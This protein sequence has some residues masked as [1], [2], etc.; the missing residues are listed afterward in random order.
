MNL[1]KQEQVFG[2]M[3]AAPLLI[4]MF[5]F[6]LW[7]IVSTFYYSFTSF[8]PLEVSRTKITISIQDEVA[9]FYNIYPGDI[10]DVSEFASIFIPS[11]FV[12]NDLRIPLTEVQAEKLDTNFNLKLFLKDFNRGYFRKPADGIS[13]LSRY[14]RT[15]SQEVFPDYRPPFVG[16]SNYIKMFTADQY[17]WLTLGNTVFYTIFVVI[18]QTILAV[19][20]AVAANSSKRGMKAF[21]LIYFIPAIT[22]SAAI[23]M[24]FSLI[25]ARPGILNQILQMFGHEGIDWL[26]EPRTALPAVMV[27]NI[28]STAG[29]FMVTF[30]AGLQGIPKELY[31]CAEIDGAGSFQRFKK[32]TIP[33]L[34]PQVVYVLIMST[35]G[36]L[37]VFD[38]VYFLLRN[39]RYGTTA[40]FLYRNAF[41]Y[42]KM[43]YASAVAVV[44]FMI[45]LAITIIQRKVVKERLV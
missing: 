25:Y 5:I 7:P 45:I 34:R 18:L 41:F 26:N 2:Y 35:I 32:I 24:V 12:I 33:L 38:Q 36:C 39:M 17:F 29:Y 28:W 30:L 16:F 10:T 13:K 11:N 21:K 8:D 3:F 37:Q 40:F 15:V 19:I 20:L 22:S 4:G 9:A 31:E 1:K 42:G 44:L 23:S 43:G 6:L 14:I 27:M